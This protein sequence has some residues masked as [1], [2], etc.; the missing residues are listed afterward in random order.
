VW[1]VVLSCKVAPSLQVSVKTRS[2][3]IP[4]AALASLGLGFVVI[5]GLTGCT[6]YSLL[7]DGTNTYLNRPAGGFLT[8]RE[9][10]ADQMTLSSGGNVSIGTLT[11]GGRLTLSAKTS[12]SAALDIASGAIRIEG[13]DVSTQTAA[14]VHTA[15]IGLPPQGNICLMPGGSISSPN[16]TFIDHPMLNGNPRALVFVTPRG[17]GGAAS[18]VPSEA[19]FAEYF[20]TSPCDS[21][22]NRWAITN[23]FGIEGGQRFNVLVIEP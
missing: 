11:T 6:N 12:T 9:N 13:A 14:F 22:N 23:A 21:F 5:G 4:D 17:N 1:T 16:A 18:N 3:E 2:S 15:H 19:Y 20:V 7:G 8:F 10:N